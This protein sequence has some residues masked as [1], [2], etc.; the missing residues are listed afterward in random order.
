MLYRALIIAML[1]ALLWIVVMRWIAGPMVWLMIICFLALFGFGNFYIYNVCCDFN[2]FSQIFVNSYI[3][4]ILLQLFW[5][6]LNFLFCFST[7]FNFVDC[8]F[9]YVLLLHSLCGAAYKP[10][11]QCGLDLQHWYNVVH[12]QL[13]HVA[14]VWHH[15]RRVVAD[16]CHRSALSPPTH[17]HRHCPY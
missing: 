10:C 4:R 14:R 9:R 13:E 7:I 6:F 5:F 1:V 2:T 17:S 15:R 3:F 12:E 11:Q 8:M 16:C